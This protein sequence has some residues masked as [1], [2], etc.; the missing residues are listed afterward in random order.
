MS[1]ALTGHNRP[2]QVIKA[3]QQANASLSAAHRQALATALAAQEGKAVEA[4]QRSQNP[5][6]DLD[7]IDCTLILV[8]SSL[9]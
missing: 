5:S 1:H 9:V 3:I 7:I 4:E 2:Q 6:V 8:H